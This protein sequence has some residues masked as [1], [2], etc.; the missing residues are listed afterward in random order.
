MNGKN[1]DE[2]KRLVEETVD[3]MLYSRPLSLPGTA[4][5][6]INIFF[7]PLEINPLAVERLGR[8]ITTCIEEF[9]LEEMLDCGSCEGKT[10]N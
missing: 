10:I 2:I 4:F 9:C 8:Y 5:G 3:A 7:D 6:V 1:T